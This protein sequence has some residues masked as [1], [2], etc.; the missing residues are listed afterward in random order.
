MPGSLKRRSFKIFT[1]EQLQNLIDREIIGNQFPYDTNREEEIEAHI[2]RL[3]YRLKR[4]PG[5]ICEA[6]W[7]HFGS[8]YASFIEFFCYRKENQFVEEKDGFREVKTEGIVIDICRLAAVAIM[9]EDDR[10]E[11]VRIETN[12]VV[13]G[14]YGSIIDG[15]CLL[16]KDELQE[17]VREVTLALEEFDYNLLAIEELRKPLPFKTKIETIY[18]EPKE[19]LVMDAIFY[20]ED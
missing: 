7:N 17:T 19:Y 6:E 8:G 18:R 3:F 14:A 20:W 4:I 1:N 16:I 13:G 9:G 5:I 10:Y 2:W 12:E 15:P 11:E